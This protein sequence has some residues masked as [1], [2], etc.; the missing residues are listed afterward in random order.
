MEQ[1]S[2]AQWSELPLLARAVSAR[3]PAGAKLGLTLQPAD[4]RL[5]PWAVPHVNAML[6]DPGVFTVRFMCYDFHWRTSLPGALYPRAAFERLLETYAAHAAK[7]SVALPLYGY[8]WPRPPDVSLPPAKVVTLA[9]LAALAARDGV[10]VRWME[11]EGELALFY[12]DA[13]GVRRMAAVPSLRTVADRSAVARRRGVGAVA[14]WHL[15]CGGVQQGHTRM[16]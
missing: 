8:D 7:L 14:F 10:E 5:R 16:L 6:E 3:L 15:G 1:L 13:G 2:R 11:Q 4:A 12:S 9:D